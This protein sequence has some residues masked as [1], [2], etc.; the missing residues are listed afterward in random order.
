MFFDKVNAEL[1]GII[2]L[3]MAICAHVLQNA[4][5]IRSDQDGASNEIQFA[6]NIRRDKRQ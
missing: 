5:S 4:F 3:V 6:I 2:M 1:C